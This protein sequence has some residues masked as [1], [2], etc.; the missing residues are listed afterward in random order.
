MPYN[1]MYKLPNSPLWRYKGP[2]ENA[3]TAY[4]EKERVE[5]AYRTS[6][7]G[8]VVAKVVEAK[9]KSDK[10]QRLDL[11]PKAYG[12][13]A[14]SQHR[15]INDGEGACRDCGAFKTSYDDSGVPFHI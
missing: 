3:S 15:Y 8:P 2:Y 4:A 9:P 6:V 12:G 7:G 14:L 10:P 13:K 11:S 5:K 1:V